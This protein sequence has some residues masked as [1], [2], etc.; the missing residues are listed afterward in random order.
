MYSHCVL[1][2]MAI[3]CMYSYWVIN[4]Y[5]PTNS[6]F[7]IVDMDAHDDMLPT[8]I[9]RLHNSH[10]NHHALL[11][12]QMARHRHWAK[13]GLTCPPPSRGCL[14]WSKVRIGTQMD[15][16]IRRCHLIYQPMFC[17]GR[18]FVTYSRHIPGD[19]NARSSQNL[20]VFPTAVHIHG[21]S[22]RAKSGC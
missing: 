2:C 4:Y 6:M 12:L 15:T 20:P 3:T 10:I 1:P 17:T 16:C 8:T 13:W 11:H 14:Q 18:A 5:M 21:C 19:Q 22:S 9:M 7:W